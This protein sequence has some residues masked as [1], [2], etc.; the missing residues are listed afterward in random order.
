M[1][2]GGGVST[3]VTPHPKRQRTLILFLG[4]AWWGCGGSHA[5]MDGSR[6]GAPLNPDLG[7]DSAPGDPASS[8]AILDVTPPN[9]AVADAS[10]RETLL[11]E[12]A[13]GGCAISCIASLIAACPYLGVSCVSSTDGSLTYS[14]YSNGVKTLLHTY[15]NNGFAGTVKRANGDICYQFT[16]LGNEEVFADSN[17]AVQ[18]TITYDY[19]AV[20]DNRVICR[21]K[22]AVQYPNTAPACVG[23]E[24]GLMDCP[25]GTCTW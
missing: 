15:S 2:R 11:P 25:P 6:D 18:A 13:G 7:S 22:T 23:N 19:D 14:C 8:D 24:P 10:G 12:V 21:D 3:D 5:E 9:D 20:G 1:K 17:N 4:L 16:Y